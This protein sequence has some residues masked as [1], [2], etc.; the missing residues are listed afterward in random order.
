MYGAISDFLKDLSTDSPALWALLVLGAMA[1][2]SLGLYLFWELLLGLVFR[3]ASR[4]RERDFFL[5]IRR[6][7]SRQ[8]DSRQG[9]SR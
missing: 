7:R 2:V 4:E 8:S 3:R 9:R 6:D 1:T 5:P